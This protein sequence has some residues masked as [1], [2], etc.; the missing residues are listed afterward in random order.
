MIFLK[1]NITPLLTLALAL[2]AYYLLQ[3]NYNVYYV[4]DTWTISNAWNFVNLGVAKDLVFIE[5]DG[6]GFRQYFGLTYSFLA[7]HFLNLFGWTKSGISLMNTGFVLATAVT[8]WFILKNLPFSKPVRLMTVL[9]LPLMPPFFFAAHAGRADAMVVFLLSLQFLA[10]IRGRYFMAALLTGIAT[11]SHIMGAVGVFYMLAYAVYKK[12]ELLFDKKNFLKMSGWMAAGFAAAG[13]YYMS[14]HWSSFNLQELEA[15]VGGKRDMSSPLNNY[16]LTYFTDFD[17]YRHLWELGLLGVATVLYIKKGF[18]RE[19]RFLLIFLLALVVSTFITRRENSNYFVYIFPVF[20]LMYFFV[21]EQMGR[22]R[23]FSAALLAV[24]AV[25]FSVIY[26]NNRNY[27]FDEITQKIRAAMP[28][29]NLPV[30]GMPDVWFAAKDRDFVPIHHT[31]DFDRLKLKK[32]YL[33]ETDYLAI[34]SRGYREVMHFFEEHAERRLL[35]TIEAGPER[36]IRIY[37]CESEPG[38]RP[39]FV[40]QEYPGWQAIA[41]EYLKDTFSTQN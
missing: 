38:V 31:R 1:E 41:K 36:T 16:I 2:T 27:R 9:F 3:E 5:P 23:Q 8:W 17:W 30:I 10:F 4:D 40:K 29:E 21:F 6:Q 7:G 35:G 13:A 39:Q 12:E 14:L 34:R 32:F 11:E 26:F 15:L 18:F 25:Y 19:N 24:L 20:L 33:V 22:L 37:A 28:D